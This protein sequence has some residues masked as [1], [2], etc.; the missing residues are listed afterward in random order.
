MGVLF[1]ASIYPIILDEYSCPDFL[2]VETCKMSTYHALV[3]DIITTS[4]FTII[5]AYF[6]YDKTKKS[7]RDVIRGE[8][9][10]I[11]NR[12]MTMNIEDIGSR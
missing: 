10:N 5:L 4:V 7:T 12:M 1:L 9:E 6:I 11:S 8:I 2:S 3:V